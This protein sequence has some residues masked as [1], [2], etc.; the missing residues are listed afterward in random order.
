MNTSTKNH[1]LLH[2]HNPEYLQCVFH[3]AKSLFFTFSMSIPYA[4]LANRIYRAAS[5]PMA[6]SPGKRFVVSLDAN[7]VKK[8]WNGISSYRNIHNC[9]C[10][11]A[12]AVVNIA[13]VK[14]TKCRCRE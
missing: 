8:K 7:R 10:S 9:A 5:F 6:P 1:R 4:A 13:S 14:I 12:V 2:N 11:F 3:G